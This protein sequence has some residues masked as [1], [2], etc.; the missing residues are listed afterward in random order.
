MYG[1]WPGEWVF[2]KLAAFM[3]VEGEREGGAKTAIILKDVGKIAGG[4]LSSA[5]VHS[6]ASY[7]VSGGSIP[8]AMGEFYFFTE[9]GGAVLFEEAI[10]MLVRRYRRR[11]REEKRKKIKRRE[12]KMDSSSSTTTLREEKE[13]NVS[14]TKDDDDDLDL[15]LDLSKWYDP[16]I[17]RTWFLG[18]ILF[19]G[20]NFARG[21]VRSGLVREMAELGKGVR[22]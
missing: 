17:G 4:F 20:R 16:H 1:V 7:C 6:F 13:I 3:G 8:D 9:N 12:L 19:S 18:V 15:D 10:Q 21:W 5:V 14:A 2:G 22:G 11:R